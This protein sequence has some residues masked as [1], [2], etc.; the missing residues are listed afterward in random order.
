MSP[1]GAALTYRARPGMAAVVCALV[2]ISTALTLSGCGSDADKSPVAE[3]ALATTATSETVSHLTAQDVWVKT[4]D[5]GMTAVFGQLRNTGGSPITIISA[6]TSASSRT[7]LHESAMVGG[8]MQMRPKKGGF[9]L[10]AG[11]TY[12]LAPGG[13]HIMVMDLKKPIRPGDRIEVKLTLI[14]GSTVAFSA[15]GKQSGAGMETYQPTPSM[16]GMGTPSSLPSSSPV[17]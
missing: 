4:A 17:K 5:S 13:N 16:A 11:T 15:L 7:E 8:S 12:A 1:D 6:I 3:A 10:P 9:T 14:D 2:S